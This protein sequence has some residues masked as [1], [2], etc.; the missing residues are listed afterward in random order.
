[1]DYQ[2]I[3]VDI[4]GQV[5]TVFILSHEQVESR[6]EGRG[7][8]HRDL[9]DALEGLR[10]DDSVRI[11]VLTGAG[12]DFAV[13]RG[14]ESYAAR[15]FRDVTS[16]WRTFSSIARC[17]HVMAEM[18]KP[19]I[20]KVN[21]HAIGFGHSLAL[22]SDLIVATLDSVFMDHHMGGVLRYVDENGKDVTV[23]HRFS[24]VPGDGGT[25]LLPLMMSPPK[26]K[27]ALML[28]KSYTGA[29]YAEMGIINYAV[30]SGQLD[31]KVEGLVAALLER[32]AYPLAWTKRAVNR[33]VADQLN[34]SLDAG[35][36]YEMAGFLQ[37]DVLQGK[38][39]LSLD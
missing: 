33:L 15:P 38:D 7:N 8:R 21:G 17:H 13:P 16:M 34:R 29:Q 24:S 11:V 9:A 12:G 10:R 22:S 36:A 37:R 5:A 4:D 35:I 26:A 25:F 19:I 28:A 30:P 3:R 27:E 18:E 20:A 14:P 31:R 32:A 1:M 6:A 23:G 2:T 39:K